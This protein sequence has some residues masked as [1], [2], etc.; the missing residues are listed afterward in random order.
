MLLSCGAP[1]DTTD[2]SDGRQWQS[3]TNY[4]KFMPSNFSSI[5]RTSEQDPSVTRVPYMSARI[6]Q[7]KFTYTFPVSPGSKFLRLYFY[8]T[9]Y[10]G[11]NKSE[12]FFSVTANHFTL[13]SNFSAFLDVAASTSTSKVLRKEFVINVNESQILKITFSP[14]PNAH[15]FVNGIEVLSMPT[16]LY[17]RG[18]GYDIKLVG[19]NNLYYINN[20]T[21]LE[22][23]YRLNVGGSLVPS[24]RDTG[25]YRVWAGDDIFV[26]GYDHQTSY[27]DVDITYNSETPAYTAP[28]I[29]YTTSRT[30]ANNSRNLDWIFPLDSGFYYLFR[31]HVCEIQLDVTKI[32]QR[33]FDIFIGNQT[34]EQQGDVIA[35]SGA[36]RV[37]ICRDY[38]VYVRDPDGRRSKKN[39]WLELRPN[40][41]TRAMYADAI[42]NGLE[43]FKLSNPNGNLAVP[44]PELRLEGPI[45]SP[46]NN[47]KM[48]SHIIVAIISGVTSAIAVFSIL[49]FLI[50]RRRNGGKGSV[51]NAPKSTES[52]TKKSGSSSVAEARDISNSV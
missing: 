37:P 21:A 4:P 18:D 48:S 29:V 19:Q 39:V 7:S 14:S 13:L 11:F 8:P 44:Y 33:V 23:L 6:F 30:I 32:N 50:F 27:L 45:K 24:T 36:W 38:V 49:G 31:L 16:N 42:L 46:N 47:N 25:M 15:A 51:T 9:T 40:M 5:S 43:I 1:S 3:D 10:L 17:V 52:T 28:T 20:S 41:K 34:A 35:W 26:V 12:S 2:E 22:T